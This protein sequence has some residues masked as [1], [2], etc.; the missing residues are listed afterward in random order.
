MEG[1]SPAVYLYAGLALTAT[2]ASIVAADLRSSKSAGLAGSW[3]AGATCGLLLFAWG[4]L[5]VVL[6]T[7]VLAER[8]EDHL[9]SIHLTIHLGVVATAALIFIVTI[10]RSWIAGAKEVGSRESLV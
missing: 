1:L 6:F 4:H 2:L 7:F 5:S 10:V 9:A 3:I 8:S